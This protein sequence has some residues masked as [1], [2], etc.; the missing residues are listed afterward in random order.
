MDMHRDGVPRWEDT[1][2]RRRARLMVVLAALLTAAVAF[3]GWSIALD[4]VQDEA[5]E[6][7]NAAC[8]DNQ[9]RA[10]AAAQRV[11]D[12]SVPKAAAL[13]AAQEYVRE[14]REAPVC[15]A[16]NVRADVAAV[17]RAV[18]AGARPRPEYPK[19]IL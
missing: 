18:K 15:F 11:N 5:D 7:L 4:R 6:R 17:E 9:G 2:S 16:D 8:Q 10:Y 19:G 3:I 1:V 13:E 14:V 12:T